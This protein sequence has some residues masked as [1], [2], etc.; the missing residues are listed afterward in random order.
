[1]QAAILDRRSARQRRA[2]IGRGEGMAIGRTKES[3][4]VPSTSGQ[5]NGQLTNLQKPKI[6]NRYVKTRDNLAVN[7]DG[8]AVDFEAVTVH[9]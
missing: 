6:G 5:P 4:L 3:R 8:Y 9:D 7:S 2:C 1:M